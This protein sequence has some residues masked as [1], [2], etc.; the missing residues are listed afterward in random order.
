M[1]SSNFTHRKA[2]DADISFMVALS[3][4]KRRDYEQAQPQFWRYATGAEDS[5]SEYFKD[6]LARD[7]HIML[8][9][10]SMN[11]VAG[12][13][14]GHLVKS[15]EVY[16]PGGLTL[17]VDDFCVE[18]SAHWQEIGSKLLAELKQLAE[19]KGAVQVLVVCGSHD[20]PKRAFL[21]DSGLKVASEWYVGE[22]Q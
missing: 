1:T 2:T 9:S 4:Q 11:K 21:M 20:D 6:L 10:E 18:S 8:I 13:I 14:I 19:A 16:D 7:D 17:K 15:P 3:H 22:I 12:F 5:Q